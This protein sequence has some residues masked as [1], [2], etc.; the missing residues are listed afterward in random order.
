MQCRSQLKC[1]TISC[2]ALLT[3]FISDRSR[4]HLNFALRVTSKFQGIF[5]QGQ[6]QH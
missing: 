3:C 6:L 2:N 5:C 1:L 4:R